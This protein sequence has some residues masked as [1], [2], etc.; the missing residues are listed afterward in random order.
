MITVL[1]QVRP[2]ARKPHRCDDCYTTIHA[3]TPYHRDT[4]VYDG[5]VYDWVTCDEC[6]ALVTLVWRWV[7]PT[8]DEGVGQ[9][10]FT[11]WA[12]E[13]RTDPVHGDAARRYLD[14]LRGAT[15]T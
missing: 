9:P 3:G 12:H 8:G 11:D 10:E 1:R 5:A 2:T 7:D 13:H 15:T 14:R 4:L 6:D